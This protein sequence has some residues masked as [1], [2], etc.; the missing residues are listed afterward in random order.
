[1]GREMV[2]WRRGKGE[3]KLKPRSAPL[4]VYWGFVMGRLGLMGIV[5]NLNKAPVYSVFTQNPQSL[6]IIIA[7]AQS[8]GF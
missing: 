7:M 5:G 8:N 6:P 1:M 4:E 2:V 3:G